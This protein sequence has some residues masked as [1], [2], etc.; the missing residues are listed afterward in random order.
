MVGQSIKTEATT[1]GKTYSDNCAVLRAHPM[2]L[3]ES[4]ERVQTHEIRNET[5][6]R[7]CAE[8]AA[9]RI[10]KKV[11]TEMFQ[12]YGEF[13]SIILTFVSCHIY[14]SRPNYRPFFNVVNQLANV[15]R[16]SH[17]VAFK[18]SRTKLNTNKTEPNFF[19]AF[20]RPKLRTQTE[21]RC[22]K[23]QKRI[24]MKYST[25]TT[26]RK[27]ANT[28]LCVFI[29]ARSRFLLNQRNVVKFNAGCCAVIQEEIK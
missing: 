12:S 13:G 15:N 5:A 27:R 22:L 2:C 14:V 21:T 8:A 3:R 11:N 17:S 6:S 10:N 18:T 24:E 4:L 28:T 19:L 26:T 25:R 16:I 1:T 7:L 29:S 23:I 9:L 20:Y